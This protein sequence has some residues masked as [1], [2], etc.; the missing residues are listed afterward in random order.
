[1]KLTQTQRLSQK[2]FKMNII[3]AIKDLS[4]KERNRKI[5]ELV[6]KEFEI[7]YSTKKYLSRSTIYAWLKKYEETEDRDTALLRKERSDNGKWRKL[8]DIQKKALTRWRYDNAYRTCEELLEELIENH[9][10]ALDN[11]P[12]LSV[13]RRFF[14]KCSLDRKTLTRRQQPSGKIRLKYEADYPNQIWMIDTKGPN[15][16]I[17]STHDPSQLISVM[18]IVVIDDYSRFIVGIRYI[19][20]G[21][22]N[23]EMVMSVLMEAFDKYGIPD[24]LYGDR[25]SP[26][27]GKSLEKALTVLG[28]KIMHTRPRDPAAKGKCEK[29]MQLYYAKID[30]ELTAKKQCETVNIEIVNE[31]A[32]AITHFYHQTRHRETDELPCDRYLSHPGKYRH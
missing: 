32:T 1:V 22:E 3:L 7:P 6:E 24:I 8:T 18:P 25:G 26:Y 14:R 5:D 29:I 9:L 15:I 19:Y 17:P 12:S 27:M 23:E 31:Y 21:E 11:A 30:T 10:A 28:C 4:P 20:M 16:K 2:A 13:I